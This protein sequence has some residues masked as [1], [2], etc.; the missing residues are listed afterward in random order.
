MA[1]WFGRWRTQF[2]EAVDR[3]KMSLTHQPTNK[4][5]TKHSFLKFVV[6]FSSRQAFVAPRC[7]IFEIRFGCSCRLIT[8]QDLPGTCT[9]ALSPPCTQPRI[10]SRSSN[11]FS[12][13]I[14]LPH[15]VK[16]P[17]TYPT[18]PPFSTSPSYCLPWL[19][20]LHPHSPD[21]LRRD[22]FILSA[23]FAPFAGRGK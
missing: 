6:L 8:P 23:H 3:H 21:H 1:L 9:L 5:S 12:A 10:G 18:E 4:K 13:I 11:K 20:S 16:P 15:F 19:L 2:I 7:S 22:V 14:R 17:C